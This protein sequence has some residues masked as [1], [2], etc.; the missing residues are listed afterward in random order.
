MKWSDVVGLIFGL[1]IVC[2]ADA[3]APSW[4]KNASRLD[5][6]A[7]TAVCSGRGPSVDL[8]RA[9]SLRSCKASAAAALSTTFSVSSTS[10]QTE[11]S[12]GL[13]EVVSIS[14]S[15]NNLSCAPLKEETIETS[16][17]SYEVWTLCKF[18]LEEAQVKATP[19]KPEVLS[20]TPLSIIDDKLPASYVHGE[21]RKL[22]LAV[23]PQCKSIMVLGSQPRVIECKSSPVLIV[24]S[25][26]DHQLIIRSDVSE[27]QP[28]KIDLNETENRDET[29]QVFLDRN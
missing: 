21:K 25:P 10:I 27:Y 7:Y 9:E 18:S 29:F 28:K 4:A 22:S 6:R 13:H 19:A 14:E 16:G 5:G 11:Q 1:P 2:S 17:S 3:G 23:I 8:A 15:F 26:Q 12:A 24:V 20:G